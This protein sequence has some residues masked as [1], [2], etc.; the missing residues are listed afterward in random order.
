[1]SISKA[2]DSSALRSI[3]GITKF[4]FS[5]RRSQ[6]TPDISLFAATLAPCRPALAA[7][8]ALSLALNLLALAGSFYML[9]VYDRVLPSRSVATLVGLTLLVLALYAF[10]GY[11][12]YIR[13]KLLLKIGVHV[14]EALNGKTFEAIVSAPLR[15]RSS[16]DGLQP[17]RDLDQVRSFL[18][19]GGP[20]VIFDLPWLPIYLGLCFLFHVWIG[21][22]ALVGAL[23]LVALTVVA[24]MRARRPAREATAAASMRIYVADAARRNA[25]SVKAMGMGP[26]VSVI[27]DRANA[28]YR[29]SQESAS[30]A[31]TGLGS[32]SRVL[33]IALQSAVLGIGAYLV[34]RQEATA[35]VIIASSILTARALTPVDQAVGNWKSFTAARQSWGRLVTL[36]A[37][38]PA[39]PEAMTLP[40][41]REK[42]TV[43]AAAVAP[44]AVP[45]LT[46]ADVTFSLTAGQGLGIIGPSASG[47]SSLARLLVGAWPAVRGAVRLDGS[48]LEDWD[49]DQ[50]GRYVGYVAQEIE[51]FPGSVAANIARFR[52]DATAE[53]VIEAAKAANVHEMIQALPRGYETDIGEHGSDLSAGQRQRIALARALYGRPFL[54]VLDEPNSNLDSEGEHFLTQAMLGV[55][56]RGGIVVVI[57]HR[58]SALAAVDH[59]LVMK[60]GRMHS[61]GTKEEIFAHTL[62]AV[63]PAQAGGAPAQAPRAVGGD[64]A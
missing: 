16:G 2:L 49:R 1:M 22:A 11:F 23:M 33:R 10:Q 36:L 20:A 48:A 64:R 40:E 41:P 56:R 14:D 35:G 15:G 17:M 6:R 12:D 62:K 57:A 58:P 24:E 5:G 46:A 31:S 34:I 28:P 60:D 13:G 32:I 27:W 37:A 19:S 4:G 26:D 29:S 51:L 21:V 50:L 52:R 47:K 42:L 59:V 53:E 44:P 45:R 55:R 54:V 7:V 25:E 61:F 3:S 9:D 18:S 8:A 39:K 63:T 43:E 38:V 30:A